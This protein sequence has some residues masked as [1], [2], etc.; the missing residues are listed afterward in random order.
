VDK[1]YRDSKGVLRVKLTEI[2][3]PDVSDNPRTEEKTY[4]VADLGNLKLVSSDSDGDRFDD[5][6][7]ERIFGDKP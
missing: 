1:I 7:L 2:H 6:M 4:A 3:T 5:E